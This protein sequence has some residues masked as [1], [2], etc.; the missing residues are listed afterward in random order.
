[1]TRLSEADLKRALERGQVQGADRLAAEAALAR[2]GGRGSQRNDPEGE[3]QAAVIERFN[4]R[5][6]EHA[7]RLIHI[8]NGGSRR[9]HEAW[10]MK[11]QG[12]RPG[13]SDLEFCQ[14]RGGYFGLWIEM[15]APKPHRSRV[16]DDQVDWIVLMRDEGYRAEV[17]RGADEALAIL[18]DY[19]AQPRT[20]VR[21]GA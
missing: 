2:K 20:V 14:A 8:P 4:A 21:G 11:C 10:R 1:M 18:E 3:A 15:K 7:R 17:A 6:P 12:V 5:H 9:R 13:V 19:L 16:T